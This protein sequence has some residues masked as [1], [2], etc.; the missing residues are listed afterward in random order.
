MVRFGCGSFLMRFVF[1]IDSFLKMI[2]L[3]FDVQIEHYA[4]IY[5]DCQKLNTCNYDNVIVV[6]TYALFV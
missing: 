4:K 5:E 6:C 1:D 2:P 3:G